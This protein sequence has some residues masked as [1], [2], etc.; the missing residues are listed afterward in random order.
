LSREHYRSVSY[1]Y[2]LPSASLVLTDELNVGD[3]ACEQAHGYHSPQASEPYEI[4]SRYEWGP[5]TLPGRVAAERNRAGRAGDFAE[6]EFEAAGDTTYTIW[7]RGKT[8]GGHLNDATWF[9]FDDHRH[10]RTGR[11][12]SHPKGFGNWRDDTPANT[13]SWSSALPKIRRRR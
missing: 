1:W 2:G 8:A 11:R 13:W 4:T 7:V 9:Q 3:A 10:D 5:D 6:F 12:Y